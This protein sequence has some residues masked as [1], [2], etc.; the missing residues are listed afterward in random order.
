MKAEQFTEERLTEVYVVERKT[1][2]DICK[3]LGISSATLYKQ[4]KKYNLHRPPPVGWSEEHR[5]KISNIMRG[6]KIT[7]GDKLSKVAKGKKHSKERCVKVSIGLK[8]YYQTHS[9]W[10]KGRKDTQPSPRKGKTNEMI[11]GKDRAKEIR[12]KS[13]IAATRNGQTTSERN[14]RLWKDEQ[15]VSKVLGGLFAKPNKAESRFMAFIEQHSL[16]LK[17]VG[18]GD[19]IIDGRVPDFVCVNRPKKLVELFGHAW[20]D[21]SSPFHSPEIEWERTSIGR[22]EFFLRRGYECLIVWEEELKDDARLLD[23]INIFL[24]GG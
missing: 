3:E 15:F 5:R 2:Q 8:K 16:P 23:G 17:Y 12:M 10:N 24:G 14:K 18:N 9:P 20:H 22:K 11:Y 1:V 6:R 4:L 7:W 19:L 21:P 13:S